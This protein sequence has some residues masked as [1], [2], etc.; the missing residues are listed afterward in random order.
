VESAD[1]VVILPHNDPDPDAIAGTLAL[2]RLLVEKRGLDVDLV[3]QG[4]IGRAENKALVRYLGYPLR[5]VEAA[6]ID[7]TWPI[8]LVDTQ[9]GAGNNALRS[10]VPVV[11]VLDHHPPRETLSE[12]GSP[13]C[14]PRSVLFRPC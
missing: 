14:D 7:G 2:R 10:D 9:P 1:R 5:P 13:M 4:I 6:D 12:V 8:A 11:I 3:Y